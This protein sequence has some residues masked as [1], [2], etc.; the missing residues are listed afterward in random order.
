IALMG[1]R[2]IRRRTQVSMLLILLSK[3][4]GNH[5]ARLL[6][7]FAKR[8]FRYRVCLCLLLRRTPRRAERASEISCPRWQRFAAHTTSPLASLTSASPVVLL[9]G[10][11]LR[12]KGSRRGCST[13]A[14][15]TIVKG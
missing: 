1:Q 5:P 2:R 8:G 9:P 10:S 14:L 11:I 7:R 15:S 13:A 12:R 4:G 3:L 6:R